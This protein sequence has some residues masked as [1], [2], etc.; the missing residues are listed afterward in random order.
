MLLTVLEAQCA[1]KDVSQGLWPQSK[2]SLFEDKV[3]FEDFGGSF[4]QERA[5]P[6]MALLLGL[7]LVTE[8]KTKNQFI[9]WILSGELEVHSADERVGLLQQ[10]KST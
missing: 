4:F 6:K 2:W 3:K 9:K 7:S 5:W 10:L 1:F 8:R